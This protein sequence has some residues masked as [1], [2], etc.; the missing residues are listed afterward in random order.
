MTLA[1]SHTPAADIAAD[2]LVIPVGGPPA[3]DPILR[4]IGAPLRDALVAEARR[5]QFTGAR[6]QE[7]WAHGVGSTAPV[8]LLLGSGGLTAPPFWF[9]V[10]DAVVRQAARLHARRV[11]VAAGDAGADALRALAEGVPLARYRFARYRSKPTPAEPLTV[12]VAVAGVDAAQ[13]EALRLGA[14]A[15]EA[16]ALTRDL[17]NT[18][19]Q[20]LA[21][22]DLARAARALARRGLRVRVHDRRALARLRMGAILGVGMGSAQPPCF[23]EISY[24]PP[25]PRRRVALVGKGITFDSGGLS[26]KT[27]DAMQAQKRDMAGAAVVLGVMSALPALRL[28]VEVRGYIASA[29]NMPSGTAIR[30]GDVLRACNGTTIEVLNTDAEG[31]LVLADALAYAARQRPDCVIDFATL[32][33]VVRTALGP[34]CAAV[35]GTDRR[36]I[37]EL[38]ASAADANEM[39]WELPLI[40]E[41]RRD[42]DSRVADLK[43]VGEGH[44]GTIVAALFLREFIAGLPWAHIDFSSTVM[45]DGFACHPKGASGYGVRTVLR[46]LARFAA[47]PASG[48]AAAAAR[49]GTISRPARRA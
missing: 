7:C 30:P 43:N 39:L 14:V 19:G 26:L 23:I 41:Y 34:R 42:I 17:A 33:A 5:R 45:S 44:S 24:R 10:A 4:R 12:T 35:L 3:D 21:P 47:H 27:A 46:W 36:L 13:R 32:T 28:P 22:M 48:V 20:D 15:A 29:E 31:R 37:G 2:L 49:R 38:I 18:P 40:E 16:T 11:T 9:E 6:G 8:V 25:R 1:L